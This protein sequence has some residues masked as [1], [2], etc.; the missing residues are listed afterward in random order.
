MKYL[1]LLLCLLPL[2]TA[3]GIGPA[4]VYKV[5]EPN[6]VE[7]IS[8]TA[9]NDGDQA[10]TYQI[11]VRGA[12]FVICGEGPFNMTG[13]TQSFSCT[14]THPS[15]LS[16]G[17][18]YAEVVVTE[19][20]QSEEGIIT[21]IPAAVSRVR[22]E[23]RREGIYAEGKLDVQATETM[24]SFI[25]N[26]YNFGTD[27][28]RAAY[29]EIIVGNQTTTTEK[30]PIG[31]MTEAVL[32]GRMA[33]PVG[34]HNATAI[35]HYDDHILMLTKDFQIG[36]ERITITN[37]SIDPFRMGD[38]AR[39][40]LSVR[41]EWPF[42]IENVRGE[43]ILMKDNHADTLATETFMLEETKEVSAFWNTADKPAGVYNATALVYYG[44][45]VATR[46]FIVTLTQTTQ[47]PAGYGGLLLGIIVFIVILLII[48]LTVR[49]RP[50]TPR[51]I[52]SPP[53]D[54]A[55]KTV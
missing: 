45:K 5:Y 13:T 20:K 29:A 7:T 26:I 4:Q 36:T 11:S 43:V 39:I 24:A 10:L 50:K 37:V 9:L 2:T 51:D 15:T 42:P 8:F 19:V 52:P 48:Y 35:V 33:L 53:K 1:V 17:A 14:L 41:N 31:S 34:Y 46:P 38:I 40:R 25:V 27:T 18:H 12:G 54:P 3:I 47:K 28:I 55:K 16:P 44:G 49:G 32:T 22:L 23:A 6:K 21:A 30:R